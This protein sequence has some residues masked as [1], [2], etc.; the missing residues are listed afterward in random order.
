MSSMDNFK[1]LEDASPAI[2]EMT[3]AFREIPFGNS[4]FQIDNFVINSQH[5]PERMYRATC[6]SSSA[7]IRALREAV[8]SRKKEDIDIAEIDEKLKSATGFDKQ[9]L[10]LDKQQKLENREYTN[11]LVE[12]A[13]YE[14]SRLYNT[15]KNLPKFTRTEFEQGEQKHFEI[16]L[17]KAVLGI[18]GARESL[19]NMGIDP[20]LSPQE[21][22]SQLT[23]YIPQ[24]KTLIDAPKDL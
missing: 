15:F 22:Q 6:L 7:K 3:E 11:K 23:G 17:K 13:L 19:D 8:Y 20:L 21:I 12:D 4:Q 14:L 18:Q 5:T 16:R 9:R 10:E 24:D 2:K 1:S